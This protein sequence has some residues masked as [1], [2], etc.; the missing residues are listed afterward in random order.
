MSF[1][2]GETTGHP[3]GLSVSR[4]GSPPSMGTFHTVPMP[5]LQALYTTH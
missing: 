1:P 2:S 5:S 4:T 3:E